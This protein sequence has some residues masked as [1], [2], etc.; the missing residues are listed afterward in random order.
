[1]PEADP[2]NGMSSHFAGLG[3]TT[4]SRNSPL[5]GSRS[6]DHPPPGYLNN[7]KRT[8]RSRRCS[9]PSRDMMETNNL[10]VLDG[11]RF[12]M[13]ANAIG[14]ALEPIVAKYITDC[15]LELAALQPLLSAGHH[16]QVRSIAHRMKGASSSLGLLRL[17]RG[18]RDLESSAARGASLALEDVMNLR[19]DLEDARAELEFRLPAPKHAG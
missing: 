1:M 18:F 7:R 16:D 14:P 9:C 19:R 2:A 6:P 10:T 11:E 5:A 13:L 8:I 12:E 3:G 15:G 4:R 17:E